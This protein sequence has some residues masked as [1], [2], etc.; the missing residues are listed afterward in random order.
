MATCLNCGKKVS[1]FANHCPYCGRDIG[2]EYLYG[3]LRFILLGTL[4]LL[5]PGLLVVGLV[6]LLILELPILINWIVAI[7]IAIYCG[8]K[9]GSLFKAFLVGMVCF[10]IFMIIGGGS[11]CPEIYEAFFPEIKYNYYD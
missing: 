11:C 4:C 6:N 9:C 10:M 5:S 1:D 7:S 8:R 2:E 3:G